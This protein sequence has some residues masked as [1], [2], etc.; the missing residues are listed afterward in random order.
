VDRVILGWSSFRLAFLIRP[1]KKRSA[2]RLT[3]PEVGI[4]SGP[5]QTRWR[6]SLRLFLPV[7]VLVG[8][9]VLVFGQSMDH[10]FLNYDDDSYVYRNKFV[11]KGLT[12]E[13]VVHAFTEKEIGLWNPL[14]S[15]SHQ[16]DVEIFGM[17][18]AGHHFTNVLFH[19][20]SVLLL[21]FLLRRMTGSVWRSAFVA[22]VFAIHPLKV[23]SVAWISER[24]DVLSGFFF[25]L[26]LMAYAEYVRN[27]RSLIRYLG[28]LVL[29]ALG[30]MCKPMVAT[31][32]LILLIVDFWPLHR[33]FAPV[34]GGGGLDWRVVREKIPLIFLS[35]LTYGISRL[36]PV[37]V[38][39][40]KSVPW[41][42]RLQQFPVSFLEYLGQFFYPADLV[43]IYPQPD[44][45]LSWWPWALTL[46]VLLTWGAY[47]L[48]T[49]LPYVWAG[50]LWNLVML[51]PVS[52]IIQIS[53]HARADHYSY[54]S[55]IGLTFG[56]TWWVVD[57]FPNGRLPRWILGGVGALVLAVLAVVAQKQTA[58]WKDCVTIWTHTLAHSGDNPVAECNFGDAY[59]R[60]GQMSDA[61]RH[62]REALRIDPGYS[63]AHYNLGNA[64]L[65]LG[66]VEAAIPEY[67]Q[68]D[69]L[70]PGQTEIH[71]NLGIA[72]S[73]LGKK[74]EGLKHLTESVRL[75][76]SYT[77]A[78]YNLANALSD[79][80]RKQEAIDTF[81]QVLQIYPS[82][83]KTHH[84]LAQTLAEMERW[85]EAQQHAQKA[86]ELQP[87]NPDMIN[88]LAWFLTASPRLDLRDG[89]RA[90]QLASA[91]NVSTGGI[92]VN[93]LRTLAAAQAQTGSYYLA[94]ATARK[95]LQL[96]E[97]SKDGVTA[98]RIHHDL[99]LYQS[100][101]V[102]QN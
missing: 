37:L 88:T 76:P 67:R 43:L 79:L 36:G 12:W 29:F 39:T 52:G 48:R 27:P 31:L 89:P 63:D 35:L 85:K 23:E 34:S 87:Q 84:N 47:A 2:I 101:K 4:S 44:V 25:L 19:G 64:L 74:E 99:Q 26:T 8:L 5:V 73:R 32:P 20:L 53:H 6:V 90:L 94:V 71:N 54:L 70:S 55:Q 61:I 86:W 72:L 24:K 102:Y 50:W 18:P 66:Q 80:G 60:A 11:S 16:M 3:Q 38:T 28:V 41:P 100:G 92:K 9:V 69:L 56:L 96:A 17:N 65:G 1:L 33:L 30:L 21:F 77:D 10:Q 68:A 42:L 58:Y 14:V 46:M 49:R 83:A 15:L 59:S 81:L 97:S 95:A 22:G 91:L 82:D 51:G 78:R 40:I 13:G 45:H 93:Y 75:D 98:R 7:L 62:Y 57:Q